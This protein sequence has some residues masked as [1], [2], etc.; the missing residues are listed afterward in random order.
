MKTNS[1]NVNIGGKLFINNVVSK[2]D[3]NSW[4]VDTGATHHTCHN[5]NWFT[6]YRTITP[7]SVT[8]PNKTVVEACHRGNVRLSD[9]LQIHDVLFLPDFAVNLISVSKLCKE[10]DC[11]VNFETNQCVIQEKKDMRKIGLAEEIDG[12]YYLKAEKKTQKQAK[13]SSVSV[14]N[15][16]SDSIVPPGILWHLRLGHLSHDRMQCMNKMYSYISVSGHVACDICQMARQRKLSFSISK[17][18]AHAMFDLVHADIWG[19]FS[20]ES[21]HGFKYFLTI[22][23]DYSRHV[24]VVMMKNKSEASEKIRS[25][26]Y[27]VENQFEKK[28]KTVRSDNGP[29]FLMQDFYAKKGIL[30]QKSCVYTPQQNGRVERRHQHILNISRALMFLSKLPKKFWSYAVLHSVFLLNRIPTKLLNNRSS[31]EVLYGQVPDLSQLKVFGCLSYASTLPVNRHKFDPRARKCAF[32]GYKS[33]MKGYILVDVHNSEVFVSRNVK[34]FDLEFPFHSLS[35]NPVPNTHIYIGS[36]HDLSAK[37]PDSTEVSISDTTSEVISEEDTLP[38]EDTDH[39]D[40]AIESAPLRKSQRVS[41]PPTHLQ[42]YVCQSSA[43]PMTNYVSYSQLTPQHQAYA[44]SISHDIEPSS[45]HQASKDSRW[46]TAM[47]TELEALNANNTWEFVDLPSGAVAIGNKWVYKIKRHADGSIERFKARLVAQG[48]TQT[49]GLDYFETFSP[50][51]KMSTI[52]VLLALASI[53]G[54]HLHQLDVNN[55]FL[56]GE[57]HETVYMKVPPGVISPKPGQVCKLLKSLY[58]LKQASRQW[59][60]KLTTFLYAQGFTQATSDHTL[61][62]KSTASSFTALLVYVDDI[63]LAGTSLT[64]FDELKLALDQ[65]FRIKNLGQLK[66]FLGIEVARSSK[67]ISLCQ[68]KYCLELLA[69]A[70]LTS[71]KPASTPL[72][73]SSRLH[74]DGGSAYHDVAAYRRL[75]GRLLYLTTTRPDIAYA[76]QQLSQFMA[77][78]TLTHHQAALRVLRYLK[79]SPGR[80]LFFP[81]SSDLQ[82]LG[83]SDADWGGCIDTRKSISGYCFFI[84]KSLV[85]WK[86]KKQNTISCSSAE[87]EYRALASATRELQWMC[88]L[89]HDLQQSPSRLPVL[90]CDNQSALHISANPVFHERTKHLDIDCHLVRE[91]LQAGVMRLLPVS[92]HNQTADFLLRLQIHA[93]FMT[94]LA[95]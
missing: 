27:M 38:D 84:G 72:D 6:N 85:S 22:L 11:I 41:K 91:K 32:L 80:G 93:S 20:T 92:S 23:D 62:I 74:L 86:S 31:Y 46:L 60:E 59:F 54:W 18:N 79:R 73:P 51:A 3:D 13:V 7:I 25:F 83:F 39:I 36:R 16:K 17:N 37:L 68:R 15:K 53:H 71:C 81:Q 69:D 77:S 61:F 48:Y 43:Y 75:V 78:P 9:T 26:V 5:L 45:F 52:R 4:I 94:V 21:I 50:V 33:G 88:F 56:H 57:L 2:I 63:I 76:T 42:D 24:W 10:Q 44:L 35:L 47:Q 14:S 1:S 49:E 82:L 95:S 8:L 29:E 30:H 19:P 70:K 55:A 67:G 58:G 87:A 12:L 40:G 65:T 66:F 28:V 34:S 90:Y 89:L 64:I